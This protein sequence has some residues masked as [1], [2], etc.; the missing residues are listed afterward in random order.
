M[1]LICQNEV[2][3]SN[4]LSYSHNIRFGGLEDSDKDICFYMISPTSNMGQRRIYSGKLDAY[5][6][7]E[8]AYRRE[9]IIS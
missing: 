4:I 9:T 3:T 2:A 1:Q 7:Y 5:E 6:V 8:N